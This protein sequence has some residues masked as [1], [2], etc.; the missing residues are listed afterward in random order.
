MTPWS[1]VA[2]VVWFLDRRV[3]VEAV[4][5]TFAVSLAR[6]WLREGTWFAV[7]CAV[8]V[9]ALVLVRIIRI[10]AFFTARHVR[11]SREWL[12]YLQF[13][14]LVLCALYLL[15]SLKG[16][17]ESP[18]Y[19]LLFIFLC[20]SSALDERLRNSLVLL[21]A[22]GI[23]EIAQWTGGP[24]LITGLFISHL[25]AIASFPLLLRVLMSAFT[26]KKRAELGAWL[27]QERRNAELEAQ[28][29]RLTTA[30]HRATDTDPARSPEKC[31]ESLRLS[32]VKELGVSVSNLLEVAEAALRPQM[33]ALYWL[34]LDEQT[35]KLRDAR[36][37]GDVLAT[38][39]IP[40]GKGLIGSLLSKKGTVTYQAR[41]YNPDL[42]PYYRKPVSFKRFMGVPL[43]EGEQEFP[44]G[45]LIADR[46]VDIPFGDDDER[47]L[48]FVARE[49]L[50]VVEVERQ[51]NGIDK[52]NIE[53]EQL[54]KGSDTLN[55]ALTLDEVMP[56]VLETVRN[57]CGEQV[58]FAALT[59]I[60]AGEHRLIPAGVNALDQW[61]DWKKQ[62]LPNSITGKDNP[63]ALAI[64][65][66][67]IQPPRN[68]EQSR[69]QLQV[70][71][72]QL[73][74][75]GLRAVKV[76]PLMVASLEGHDAH[77]GDKQAIGALV[78]GSKNADA[79]DSKDAAE[80]ERK[81]AMIDRLRIFSNMAATSIQNAQRYEQIERMATT[82]G[83]TG[84]FNHRRFQEL[85]DEAVTTA[86]RY[87]RPLSLILADV[88]HFKKIND[89]FGHPVGDQVLK[90]VAQVL[91]QLA[92]SADRVCRYGG[93][94][95]TVI[96]PE[97][98]KNGGC[99]LAERFREEIKRQKFEVDGAAFTITV[100]L[101]VCTIPDVAHHKQELIDR[102]DQALYHAKHTG[103]DRTVHYSDL[104]TAVGS[105]SAP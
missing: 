92:R 99:I 95:F 19:P 20:A 50:R 6:G 84:L 62:N 48:T 74:V 15:I 36:P 105:R 28:E 103:R 83:L 30:A 23:F 72:K 58:G 56:A 98:D 57:M 53:I 9:S 93:E 4:V 25:L 101:G 33:V 89:T 66:G 55:Q 54:K 80:L 32:S 5:A 76:F 42:T 86:A 88:D 11:N 64:K 16:G 97:T 51:L 21:L 81:R 82:D 102:A 2:L 45:V 94:E 59:L 1:K 75:P 78:I 61:D 40:A 14:L 96:M 49:I 85:I 67:M 104:N 47:V 18:L 65:T 37:H 46:N 31:Q 3:L 27:E 39:P 17:I 70:F 77:P 10:R 69:E 71:G 87:R 22:S 43:L 100:S 7:A 44:R 79:F 8:V 24:R 38:G 91:G 60:E 29:Y 34:S 68:S 13:E 26:K 52:A 41:T 90:R 73:P 12:D 63:C 35:V